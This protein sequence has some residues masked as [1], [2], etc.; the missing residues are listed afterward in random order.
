MWS[1][2]ISCPAAVPL[3]RVSSRLWD[4]WL[5]HGCAAMLQH[6]PK[7][8]K[9]DEERYPWVL[10][11]QPAWPKANREDGWPWVSLPAGQT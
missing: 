2:M 1:E 5:S 3:Q 7:A 10:L 8:A 4:M 11:L 9:S 6:Q